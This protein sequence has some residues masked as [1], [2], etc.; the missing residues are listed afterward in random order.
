MKRL[1]NL[2]SQIITIENLMKADEKA[3]K[4]KSR[5][6]G[7]SIHNKS[8]EENIL[9]LHD[10]LISK[11]YKT[12]QY[13]IFKVFEPKER[14]VYRLPYFP[15]RI[16][17]HAI[18]NILEPVFVAVFTVDSYSCIKGRGIH[19]A[20]FNL[21]KALKKESETT[22]CL[23]LDI[24]KFYPNI[25]HDV[26]KT[27]LRRKFKDVEFLWLVDEIIDSAP[28]LP[29][30]NYLSQYLAN[31]YLTYFDHWIKEK[32]GIRYYFRYADDIVILHHDKTYLHHLLKDIENYFKINLKLEVKDNWQVFPVSKRGI[33]FVGYKHYHSHILLRKSIKKRFAKMMKRNPN[34]SSLA[35]YMGWAKHCNSKHLLKKIITDVQLQRFKH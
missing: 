5:Q 23:K 31:F 10:L 34:K 9:K 16:C 20:S 18:M 3:Q 1:N 35:S 26:L 4:G 27:L 15:D 22:F 21:R 29:I 24:K 25:D 30:G 12:S 2:F 7:V 6:Y 19:K 33:D 32:I 14:E 28:G 11:T 13:D 8:K 17:H